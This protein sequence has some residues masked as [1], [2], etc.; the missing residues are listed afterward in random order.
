MQK[1]EK[2]MQR[3]AKKITPILIELEET[4]WE[5]DTR[6]PECQ[7]YSQDA[8]RAA[9]KIF[10]H[11]AMDHI[12]Q[13]QEKEDRTMEERCKEVEDFGNSVGKLLLYYTGKDSKTFYNE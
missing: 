11:L 5:H 10:M 3:F 7:N 2:P 6:E 8:L 13:R 12:W 9:T 1:E 4:I